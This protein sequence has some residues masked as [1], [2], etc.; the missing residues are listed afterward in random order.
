MT[1]ASPAAAAAFLPRGSAVTSKLRLARYVCSPMASKRSGEKGSS[2]PVPDRP[3]EAD[4]RLANL[5]AV[6]EIAMPRRRRR[7]EQFSTPPRWPRTNATNEVFHVWLGC[8]VSHH[9]AH[10]GGARL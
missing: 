9:R 2:Q 5:G 8:Y 4:R 6:G 7:A 10:R 3:R 1:N